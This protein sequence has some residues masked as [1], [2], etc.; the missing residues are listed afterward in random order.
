MSLETERRPFEE[1]SEF[2]KLRKAKTAEGWGF[3]GTDGLTR[4]KFSKDARFEEVPFQTEEEIKAK[5]LMNL[6]NQHP[7]HDFEIELILDTNTPKLR[8]YKKILS[9]EE[10]KNII[11]NLRPEDKRYL[12]FARKKA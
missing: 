2:E 8:G 1:E 5:Q 3:L 11:E 9:E 4:T 7:E 10:Y 6:K 12:I